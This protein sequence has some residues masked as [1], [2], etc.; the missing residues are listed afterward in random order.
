MSHIKGLQVL[1][2]CEENQKMLAKLPEWVTS[3][4]N[5]YVTEQLDEARTIQALMSLLHTSL[6]RHVLHVFQCHPYML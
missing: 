6:K 5:R 3:R 1:N 2:D 4:W